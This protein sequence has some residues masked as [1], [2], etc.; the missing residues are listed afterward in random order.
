M[1]AINMSVTIE[2]IEELRK[3]S[4][5]SYE[6]AKILLEKHN[7][8]VVEAI[9]DLEK[10]KKIDLDNKCRGNNCK[11]HGESFSKI[12]KLF[13]K[14]N[15]IKFLVTKKGETIVKVPLNFLLFSL[16]VGFHLM[17]VSLV[18]IIVTGCKMS[19]QKTEGEVVD[20]DDAILD[21]AQKVKTTAE[22]FVKEENKSE[23]INL[24]K[25]KKENDEKNMEKE[26]N[27]HTVE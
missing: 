2:K 7:G 21:V 26:Y 16:V 10:N 22:N 4:K 24:S 13:H 27:E 3:R 15:S 23:G 8:N 25:E 17:I 11:D 19:I 20:V 14:G 12:K 9:I 5:V 6:E 18:L 1:G